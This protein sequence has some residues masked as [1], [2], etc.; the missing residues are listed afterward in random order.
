MSF[1]ALTKSSFRQLTKSNR[2][3]LAF[4]TS[5]R[6][7]CSRRANLGKPPREPFVIQTRETPEEWRK[8]KEAAAIPSTP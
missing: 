8:R 5:A 7:M 4:G 3:L 1:A 2:E 6:Y